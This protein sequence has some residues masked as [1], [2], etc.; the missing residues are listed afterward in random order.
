MI[1]LVIPT[2]I[3]LSYLNGNERRKVKGQLNIDR[4]LFFYIP[5]CPYCK[6]V[7]KVLD[8]QERPYTLINVKQP[9]NKKLMMQKRHNQK[10]S[11]PFV[12][13]DGKPIDESDQ[14]IDYL[15]TT[16]TPE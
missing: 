3:I 12:I 9:K 6:R 4:I 7:Q 16:W 5:G 1:Y 2:L 14:I 8:M 10:T 13:I 11:V 15:Y